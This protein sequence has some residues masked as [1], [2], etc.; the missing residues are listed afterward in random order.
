MIAGLSS[1]YELDHLHIARPGFAGLLLKTDGADGTLLEN[2][3]IH[4]NSIHD[5]GGE[6]MYLGETKTTG[7]TLRHVQIW[8][9]VV[10]RSGWEACQIAHGAEDVRV[11]NNVFYRAGLA[12]ELWQ[13]NNLQL[14]ANTTAEIRDNL[15]IGAGSHLLIA[16]GGLAKTIR[17][18]YF[19]GTITGPGISLADSNIP[20]IAN[21]TF[22]LE[23]NFFRGVQPV[24]PV[25][26][27]LG[28]ETVVTATNNAWAG[29][30]RFLRHQP[31]IDLSQQLRVRDN[32]NEPVP[33]PQFVD[34]THDNFQL[35][36]DDPYRK[37]GIGLL[38]E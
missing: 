17:N 22:T 28:A 6:G 19:E 27:F 7:Q 33:R 34:E 4:D 16:F 30:N 2:L 15:V 11:H 38:P 14:S 5:A 25:L 10:V 12:G 21:T 26:L 36:P 8:N 18:N 13:D 24:Q 31:I 32:R 9:N 1:D 23:D 29:G 37:L 20:A 35:V 3:N